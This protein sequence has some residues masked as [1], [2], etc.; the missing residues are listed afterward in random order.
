M[1]VPKGNLLCFL[2]S[3]A[4]SVSTSELLP[5]SWVAVQPLGVGVILMFDGGLFPSQEPFLSP[6][7]CMCM[8]H[9]ES[10]LCLCLDIKSFVLSQG[11]GSG[12]RHFLHFLR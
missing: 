5:L 3:Q 8:K 11:Q 10:M 9:E 1:I 12:Q 2:T 4:N 7:G 6:D